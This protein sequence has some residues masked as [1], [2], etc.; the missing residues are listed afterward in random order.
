MVLLSTTSM[1]PFR[2]RTPAPRFIS[3]RLP[4][5]VIEV[6]GSDNDET[7][8]EVTQVTRSL[9]PQQISQSNGQRINK[10]KAVDRTALSPLSNRKY[11]QQ[12]RESSVRSVNV[13]SSSED[14]VQHTPQSPIRN[15]KPSKN[16]ITS[17]SDEELDELSRDTGKNA[18]SL[19]THRKL[20]SRHTISDDSIPPSPST[21]D[22][23]ITSSIQ[24]GS[25]SKMPWSIADGPERDIVLSTPTSKQRTR[26]Y[27]MVLDSE[28]DDE[29]DDH[30][31]PLIKWSE[32][33]K[34]RSA[35]SKHL[36]L[37]TMGSIVTDGEETSKLLELVSD[38]EMEQE[39]EKILH[40]EPFRLT[41]YHD[42]AATAM[43]PLQDDINLEVDK[44]LAIV[45]S[46]DCFDLSTADAVFDAMSDNPDDSDVIQITKPRPLQLGQLSQPKQS[47]EK[48]EEDHR[49]L[50]E[51]LMF[52]DD[53]EECSPSPPPERRRGRIVKNLFSNY[54]IF[55]QAKKSSPL[56]S[57][58][59]PPKEDAR[60][61]R[62]A[63]E[64][65]SGKRSRSDVLDNGINPDDVEEEEEEELE[66]PRA[67]RR[68][69]QQSIQSPSKKTRLCDVVPD[70]A[71]MES[72]LKAAA[73]HARQQELAA[74]APKPPKRT[75]T[76]ESIS[77]FSDSQPILTQASLARIKSQEEIE[78]ISDDAWTQPAAR[79]RHQRLAGL[80][81]MG[82]L[83]FALRSAPIPSNDID[84]KPIK[85]TI[86][87]PSSTPPVSPHQ[88]QINE[89]TEEDLEGYMSPTLSQNMLENCPICQQKI[90]ADEMIAHVEQELLAHDLQEEEARQRQ[91]E[92]L[93]RELNEDEEELRVWETIPSQD[94]A[95]DLE[96]VAGQEVAQGW[97][98]TQN[99]PSQ[100][101]VVVLDSLSGSGQL[102]QTPPKPHLN[103]HR[104]HNDVAV[105]SRHN[106]VSLETPTRKVSN[107][108]LDSPTSTSKLSG[109]SYHGADSFTEGYSAATEERS[110]FI[111]DDDHPNVYDI[112]GIDSTSSQSAFYIQPGQKLQ[113]DITSD[114][115]ISIRPNARNSA[116][117]SR[118]SA[119]KARREKA[120]SPDTIPA[121]RSTKTNGPA[122]DDL[123]DFLLQPEP[124]S[125]LNRSF[126]TKEKAVDIG[127][128][129]T[130]SRRKSLTKSTSISK[131]KTVREPINLDDSEDD[132][133]IIES[134][135]AKKTLRGSKARSNF[136]NDLLP[137]N[138]RQQR[139]ELLK[140]SRRRRPGGAIVD[141]D[142]EEIEIGRKQ[143]VGEKLWN[144]EDDLFDSENLDRR[145]V[146]GVGLG[147]V[148]GGI[149]AVTGSLNVSKITKNAVEAVAAA[150]VAAP[151]SDNTNQA[152]ISSTPSKDKAFDRAFEHNYADP[153][154]TLYTCPSS[155]EYNDPNYGLD[156]QDL[157][158]AVDPDH[159]MRDRRAAEAN[160]DIDDDDE[161]NNQELHLSPLND[162]IDL[163]KHQDDPTMAMYFAQFGTAEDAEGSRGRGRARKSGKSNTTT[164]TNGSSTGKSRVSFG[165]GIGSMS[166]AKGINGTQ[167]LLTNF[168]IHSDRT[169]PNTTDD[170]SL[171]NRV[172][173]SGGYATT[174]N[175]SMAIRSKPT[176]KSTGAGKSA[177]RGG[178]N[179]RARKFRG[180][181]GRGRGHGRNGG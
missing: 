171:G 110:F 175:G 152:P 83:N 97:M 33:R 39:E 119:K 87:I 69:G 174:A 163:R 58:K 26:Y 123:D 164:A 169:D 79:D 158:D 150:A 38:S 157:W 178:R 21:P 2:D 104:R 100:D 63:E 130:P 5:D 145:Q 86:D 29:S 106:A 17:V 144:Q 155:F 137:E 161:A 142:E 109:P 81:V 115:Y 23:Q 74:S 181:R 11:K 131:Q 176:P 36:R 54:A 162:F 30:D 172:A 127:G 88:F 113:D 128:S 68:S 149:G 59:K 124:S 132:D 114:A 120:S 96:I 143:P 61:L 9:K 50:R 134:K 98:I 42:A 121:S 44:V 25:T 179:W 35:S 71:V 84:Q 4:L 93:A 64:V 31:D 27:N 166:T 72:V 156:S 32:R 70:N 18:L 108:S 43:E 7:E 146:K 80:R 117:S 34:R 40:A 118:A 90:P 139:M 180:T 111:E 133:I 53:I 41:H 136:M 8:I 151:A 73:A 62:K 116:S 12:L 141:V 45:R 177:W 112:S 101:D 20:P 65:F 91:D 49:K 99:I 168:G 51:T 67:R 55:D 77:V 1:S 148:I 15:R 24:P 135:P 14:E 52:T 153:N 48:I 122:D 147:G 105:A 94:V 103:R 60:I 167:S 75:E 125:M 126:R 47:P 89:A 173:S 16:T 95:P 107:L 159:R 165:P 37:P 19:D 22:V 78:E 76:F 56:G 28:D 10:G 66:D 140:N 57:D 138:V 154:N 13:I 82:S 85:E 102:T 129:K 160:G 46:Q 3:P 6:T 92:A 170:N